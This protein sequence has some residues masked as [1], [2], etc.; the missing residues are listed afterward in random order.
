MIKVARELKIKKLKFVGKTLVLGAALGAVTFG[1]GYLYLGAAA[2]AEAAATAGVITAADC[3]V[4]ASGAWVF[5]G[6]GSYVYQIW[7]S[8]NQKIPNGKEVNAIMM[9]IDEFEVK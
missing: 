7:T 9:K 6:Y 4:G 5:A 1:A 3:V 2:F 8:E